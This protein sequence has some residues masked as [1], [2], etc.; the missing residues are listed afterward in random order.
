MLRLVI[1]PIFLW[2]NISYAQDTITTPQ[3]NFDDKIKE[4]R[5][6]SGIFPVIIDNDT[7]FSVVEKVNSNSKAE[8][9]LLCQ[10]RIIEVL[11]RDLYYK[12]SIAVR[13]SS[14]YILI[15]YSGNTIVEFSDITANKLNSSKSEISEK[16]IEKFGNYLDR[17]QPE[18]LLEKLWRVLIDIA[19]YIASLLILKF[20]YRYVV[21][22]LRKNDH[23]IYKITTKL[24]I[25]RLKEEDKDKAVNNFLKIIKSTYWIIIGLFT[26]IMVPVILSVF[27]FTKSI[28]DK[29]FGYV[30]DP[31][32]SFIYQFVDYIPT[33]I[34]IVVILFIF[35]ATIKLVNYFFREI[36]NGNIYLAGFYKEWAT[37][38]SNIVKIFIYAFLIVII[39]PLLP[40]S[41]SEVFKGV[42]MFLGLILSLGSTSVISNA[43]S[44]LIMTY[45]RPFKIGDRIEADSVVG[46]VVQKNLLITRVR[47]PKNVIITIPN[48]KI[49]SGHSKNFTTAA[50]RSNL[51]IHSSIT[52]GYDV[53]WRIVHKLLIAASKNTA[54][55][56]EQSGKEAFVLQKSLDDFYVS[57][58]VNAYISQADK[59]LS[60][61]S[62]LFRNILD[63]FNKAGVEIMSPHYQANRK[64]EEITTHEL[65][66]ES[67]NN[68]TKQDDNTPL[69]IN[70]KINKKA[71]EQEKFNKE[72]EENKNN[73]K[74]TGDNT[75]K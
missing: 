32:L 25:Y 34:K 5:N 37:P 56:I 27:H 50:E 15:T 1:I 35:R 55:T 41:G 16:Y 46:I 11:Q 10:K 28:G 20:I 19:I 61:Q 60:I 24:K 68:D 66:V 65:I 26:Y 31:F 47:T 44:G 70:E 63:E 67:E 64:G 54:G 30:L 72:A 3:A 40:G 38:T 36:E 6:E 62:D 18:V 9:A 39:F 12:D 75:S 8:Q 7:V 58:E 42:S 53:D 49:L 52:I 22:W 48:A 51:I 74:Q 57:Y 43:L 71:E 59:Y 23:L 69:D 73:D 4:L 29:M 21:K 45:M 14:N 13:D 2:L 17:I 33:M